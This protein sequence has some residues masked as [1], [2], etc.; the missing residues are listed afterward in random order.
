MHIHTTTTTTTTTTNNHIFNLLSLEFQHL[1][2]RKGAQLSSAQLNLQPPDLPQWSNKLAPNVTQLSL[3]RPRLGA[4]TRG[5]KYAATMKD[6]EKDEDENSVVGIYGILSRV[7]V[8]LA[9]A[10]LSYLTSINPLTEKYDHSRLNH[11][12]AM[13]S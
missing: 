1:L 4:D 2:S 13:N 10:G 11:L 7:G 8:G 9:L 6:D 5:D 12:N 3:V